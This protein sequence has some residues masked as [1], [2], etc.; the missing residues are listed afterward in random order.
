MKITVLFRGWTASECICMLATDDRRQHFTPQK[1]T[2]GSQRVMRFFEV[3]KLN[4]TVTD[5]STFR[6]RWGMGIELVIA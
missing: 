5:L 4:L 3:C 6:L 1:M 2:E